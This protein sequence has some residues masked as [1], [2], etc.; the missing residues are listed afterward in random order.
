[1]IGLGGR[2]LREKNMSII[3]R[4][5]RALAKSESGSDD[6]DGL[7]EGVQ[8]KLLANVRAVIE[9]LRE[10]SPEM[11][12]DLLLTEAGG[13]IDTLKVSDTWQVMIDALLAG[14]GG[15]ATNRRW[16]DLSRRSAKLHRHIDR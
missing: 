6:W 10:P 3:E 16:L 13:G 1:M 5:A 4:A 2:L 12:E 15:V 14:G 8:Q 9:A 7:D 11:I